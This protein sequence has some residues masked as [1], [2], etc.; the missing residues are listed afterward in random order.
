MAEDPTLRQFR[1]QL[2]KM[3][4]LCQNLMASPASSSNG[5]PQGV[6]QAQLATLQSSG[7][8]CAH[9]SWLCVCFV[10]TSVGHVCVCVLCSPLLA[11]GGWVGACV[12]VHLNLNFS[13]NICMVKRFS[14]RLLLVGKPAMLVSQMSPHP[15]SWTCSPS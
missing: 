9:L 5:Q 1:Q 11:V 12:D 3:T 2:E 13:V 4:S 14:K 8:R 7:Q 15:P 6:T 10:L